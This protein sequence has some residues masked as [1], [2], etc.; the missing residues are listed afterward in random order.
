MMIVINCSAHAQTSLQNSFE[1]AVTLDKIRQITNAL[2][3]GDTLSKISNSYREIER[4]NRSEGLYET[5][6][7]YYRGIIPIK[8]LVSNG[9][10][11]RSKEIFYLD[12]NTILSNNYMIVPA[13]VD[14]KNYWVLPNF[15]I[16]LR[17]EF[18]DIST[19]EVISSKYIPA[20]SKITFWKGKEDISNGVPL[21]I[22][23]YTGARIGV[24][25]VL[26]YDAD[27]NALIA[28]DKIRKG[29]Y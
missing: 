29:N 15:E 5:V 22:E 28:V 8:G 18:M 11:Q 16:N 14:D 7:I 12:T 27:S 2:A 20:N 17:L 10:N 6:R 13:K 1:D 24:F 9:G 25:F 19:G 23:H 21:E 3:A 4:I 26:W